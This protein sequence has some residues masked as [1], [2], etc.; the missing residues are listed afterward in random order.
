MI[1]PFLLDQSWTFLDPGVL[2]DHPGFLGFT[3]NQN[4]NLMMVCKDDHGFYPKMVIIIIYHHYTQLLSKLSQDCPI[5]LILLA[6]T[7][8]T[9]AFVA[10]ALTVPV[11]RSRSALY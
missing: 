6:Y 5:N 2:D 3:Q 8:Y 1:Q 10:S 9:P 7:D 4:M 11:R